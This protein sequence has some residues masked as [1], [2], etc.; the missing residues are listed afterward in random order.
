MNNSILIKKDATTETVGLIVLQQIA[1]AT[2]KDVSG[3]AVKTKFHA[4]E[5][6]MMMIAVHLT[7]QRMQLI[8]ANHPASGSDDLISKLNIFR[9]YPYY[10]HSIFINRYHFF[11]FF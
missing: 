5:E 3:Q 6:H 9:Q 7:K 4:L 1:G 11:S 8:I 2:R 10:F